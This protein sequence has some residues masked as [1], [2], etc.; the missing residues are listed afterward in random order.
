MPQIVMPQQGV[1]TKLSTILKSALVQFKY[2]TTR[3]RVFL[4]FRKSKKEH[5][6]LLFYRSPAT[7]LLIP[8]LPPQ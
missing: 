3:A 7:A 5:P 6:C 1:L 4:P 8:L 2:P